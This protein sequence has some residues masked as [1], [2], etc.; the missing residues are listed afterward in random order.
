MLLEYIVKTWEIRI[1]Q[2]EKLT[3]NMVTTGR[4]SWL[5]EELWSWDGL[6]S[7]SHIGGL[8]WPAADLWLHSTKGI[9]LSYADPCGWRQFPV[10]SCSCEWSQP[11]YSH[12]LG[13]WVPRGSQRGNLDSCTISTTIPWIQNNFKRFI[14][15]SNFF[16]KHV[17]KNYQ[18]NIYDKT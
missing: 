1:R 6:S 3:N 12:K 9:I 16:L 15:I 7:L 18:I 10:E 5:S 14:K 8:H 2:R 17:Y 4:F 11:C 13:K